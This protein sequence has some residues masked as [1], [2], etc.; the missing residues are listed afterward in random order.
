M[1]PVMR[2]VI[3]IMLAMLLV[4]TAHAAPPRLLGPPIKVDDN[5]SDSVNY[6][7]RV[8]AD[9]AVKDVG[10]CCGA[11][12]ACVNRDSPTFP[13]RVKAQCAKNH[14]VGVC[15]YPVIA[16]CQCVESRCAAASD[17]SH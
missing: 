4:A 11:Y 1:L 17:E 16:G 9:C 6:S 14:Q 15:N 13:D 2:P 3:A 8:D 7:C 10:N 12:P 5:A